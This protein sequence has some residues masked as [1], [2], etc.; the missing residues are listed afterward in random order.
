LKITADT[1]VL[2]RSV[3]PDDKAQMR[4]AQ[5]TLARATLVAVPVAALCE[6]AWVLTQR[7]KLSGAAVATAIRAIANSANVITERPLVDAGLA[8][9]EAGGDFADGVIAHDGL[10][11]GADTFVSFDKRA[12]RVLSSKGVSAKLPSL[13]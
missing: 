3:I 2:L 5:A 12:V 8:V 9:M 13:T 10:A 6:F 11:H 7:Y 1:N 4:A